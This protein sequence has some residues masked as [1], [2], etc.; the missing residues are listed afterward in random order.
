MVSFPQLLLMVMMMML[1]EG[2][3]ICSQALV[4]NVDLMRVRVH[5]LP[6]WALCVVG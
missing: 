5:V 3:L 6:G 1:P 2:K 4:H